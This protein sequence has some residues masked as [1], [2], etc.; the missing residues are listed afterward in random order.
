M[1]SYPKKC[2][3]RQTLLSVWSFELL[4]ILGGPAL[5]SV[6]T[7]YGKLPALLG[8]IS[9]ARSSQGGL[10]LLS[11]KQ[12]YILA[13]VLTGTQSLGLPPYE[14]P[15]SNKKKWISAW[16]HHKNDIDWWNWLLWT[17][18]SIEIRSV[19]RNLKWNL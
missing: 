17:E 9:I 8:K 18:I 16:S 7:V 14:H 11:Y 6:F 15:L 19:Y 3:P 2:W 1:K 5:L 13:K 4:A 12:K 10:A